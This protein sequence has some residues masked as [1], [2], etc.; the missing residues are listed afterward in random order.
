[1]I[2]QKEKILNEQKEE[3]E[4]E[5]VELAEKYNDVRGKLESR[6]DELNHKNMNFE[7]DAALMRQ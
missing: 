1:L 2:A 4:L 6:E 7:K 5:K 3:Y